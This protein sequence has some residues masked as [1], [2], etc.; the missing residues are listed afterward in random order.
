MPTENW[1]AVSDNLIRHVWAPDDAAAGEREIT[2]DPSWYADNGTPIDPVTG[3]DMSYV[4]TE[5]LVPY[6]MAQHR[7]LSAESMTTDDFGVHFTMQAGEIVYDA[8]T[9]SGHWA[10]MTEQSFKQHAIGTLGL[11]KGQKYMRQFNKQLW[12]IEG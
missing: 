9:H 7:Y 11:G 12:K 8:R 4:R 3:D 2:V 10:T 1:I 5:I 6:G